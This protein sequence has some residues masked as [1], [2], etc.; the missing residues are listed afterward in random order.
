MLSPFF[1]FFCLLHEA[2]GLYWVFNQM[3]KMQSSSL[4][5]TMPLICPIWPRLLYVVS[6]QPRGG[7]GQ[8]FW[9]L[10][11]KSPFQG[12]LISR[13]GCSSLTHLLYLVLYFLVLCRFIL[14]LTTSQF[15][16]HVRRSCGLRRQCWL[17][18][19]ALNQLN[20]RVFACLLRWFHPAVHACSLVCVNECASCDLWLSKLD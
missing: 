19:L 4:Q 17:C 18:T 8:E 13:R 2:T 7:R 1:H 14:H 5:G 9:S 12:L 6:F 11:C 10:L 15:A 20:L 3:C 16:P